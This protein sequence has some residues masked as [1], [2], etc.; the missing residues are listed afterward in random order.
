MLELVKAAYNVDPVPALKPE[1]KTHA[2][3]SNT[4]KS[5]KL[6]LEA[7]EVQ[8]FIYGEPNGTHEVALIF[9]YPKKEVSYMIPKIGLCL[10][11]FAVGELATRAFSGGGDLD[12]G[13]EGGGGLPP[14]I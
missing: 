14:P 7:K 5:T 1:V 12:A 2:N 6:E 9:E 4:Y 11:S 13:E 8:I 3:R 10:E